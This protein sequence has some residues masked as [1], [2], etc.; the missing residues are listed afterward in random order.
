MD[1]LPPQNVEA[2]RT[3]LG[4][5]FIDPESLSRV[6]DILAPE[7]FYNQANR[8]IYQTMLELFERREPIDLLTVTNRLEEQQKI[9]GI[10]G[11]TYLTALAASVPTS[12]HIKQ[13]AIIVQRKRILR[14]L[15]STAHQ[16]IE[17]GYQEKEEIENLLD[18]AEQKLFSVSQKSLSQEFYPVQK[19]LNEAFERLDHLHKGNG[20]LRGVSTGFYELDSLTA[21]LQKSDLIILASRPSIG[22]TSLALDIARHTASKEKIPVGIF[23]LEMSREQVVDRLL[24]A[25]SNVSL[26]KMRTGRLSA[27][28]EHNDFTRISYAMD[29]L[30]QAPIFIDDAPSPTVLQMRAMARRLQAEQPIGLLIVDYLQLIRSQRNYDSEVQQFT[31]ISRNLKALSRELNIPVLALSQLSRAVESRHDQRP[32]LSDLRSSGSIEQDADLVMFIYREDKIRRDSD[33]PNIAEIILAKHRNGP[34]GSFELYFSEE[35]TSFRN[36]AKSEV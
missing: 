30:S 8:L 23:S 2:E 29:T 16:I 14:D 17:L 31:E 24:A 28:G 18:L 25:E 13:Y 12:A 10:G 15:I 9:N 3:V 36:L 19:A 33:K 22:K 21:G 20:I 5:I 7:D 26:W 4:S 27:S 34:T 11:V 6:A 32:K 1:K 35:H